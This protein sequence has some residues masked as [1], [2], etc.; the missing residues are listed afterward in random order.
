MKILL[1]EHA[2]VVRDRLRSLM[3]GVPHAVLVAEAD[4]DIAARRH[5]AAY[6]PELVILDPCLGGGG[7]LALIA[8]IRAVQPGTTIIVL[9]N[10]VHPEYQ[11]RCLELGADHFFDKSK[12]TQAFVERLAALCLAWSV[13]SNVCATCCHGR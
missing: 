1:V 13:S 9:T 10:Q 8:H 2:W 4:S 6:R 11:A 3:A 12:E 5:L 7:G